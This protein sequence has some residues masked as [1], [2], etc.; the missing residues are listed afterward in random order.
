MPYVLIVHD[1]QSYAAW[2][3]VFDAAAPL[4][5]SAGELSYELLCAEDEPNRI[6]H[7][8]RWQSLAAARRF[9]ESAELA[10]IRRRAGVHAPQF[11]YLQ[12]LEAAA[13]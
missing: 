4:R 10:A 3:R 6:V 5:K 8:S 13:L 1:V 9:F 7:F 12:Q 2:K 11:H